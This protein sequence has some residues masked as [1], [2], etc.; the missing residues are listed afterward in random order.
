MTNELRLSKKDLQTWI[1][2]V[3]IAS[4][5]SNSYPSCEKQRF[6]NFFFDVKE[7]MVKKIKHEQWLCFNSS[8]ITKSLINTAFSIKLGCYYFSSY[9][10]T[11]NKQEIDKYL[12]RAL[13]SIIWLVFSQDIGAYQTIMRRKKNKK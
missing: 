5:C 1:H 10:A 6:F 11:Q 4:P 13:I 3:S 8:F 2:N 12:L 9:L 7:L